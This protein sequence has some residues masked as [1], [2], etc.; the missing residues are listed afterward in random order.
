MHKIKSV[1]EL[2]KYKKGD[3]AYFIS[4]QSLI[5]VPEPPQEDQWMLFYHPKIL[6]SR[7]GPARNRWPLQGKLPKLEPISFTCL[8]DL[9]SSELCVFPFTITDV[10]RSRNTGEYLYTG[11]DNMSISL[12]M[13]EEYLLETETAAQKEI[14]RIKKMVANWAGGHV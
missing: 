4:Y 14:K 2:S 10:S 12:N 11:N 3:I 5:D 13:P 6:F 8:V 7:R 1:L 9:L